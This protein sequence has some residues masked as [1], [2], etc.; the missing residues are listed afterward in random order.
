MLTI[1]IFIIVL[2]VIVFVH[3]FGHFIAAKRAGVRVDEFGFGF[4]PRIF[5]VRRGETTYSVN[6]IPLGG[7]VKLHGEGGEGRDDPRSF[8]AK[9]AWVRAI[10]LLAGV[11]MNVVLA[12]FLLTIGFTFGVRQL[13]DG[14]PPEAIVSGSEVRVLQVLP[15]APA[16]EAGLKS[17]DAIISVGGVPLTEAAGLRERVAESDGDLSLVVRRGT[18]TITLTVVP[19]ELPEA[20][21]RAIGVLPGNVGTVRYPWYLAPVKG[22]VAAFTLL[23][24]IA[25]AFWELLAGLLTG[26]GLTADLS[27]PVGIAVVTGEATRLGIMYLLQ[28]TALLSLNLAVLNA[29]PFPALDGGRFLFL[30][31][32]KL[33]GRP[34]PKNAEAVVHQA[35][36]AVLMLLVVAV[37]YRDL[38]RYGSTIGGFFRGLF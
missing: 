8:A 38:V 14:L 17:G 19:R 7:F 3:E 34:L 26:R 37:T 15:G 33:R 21:G 16:H 28:F 2:G 6:L 13:T 30:V 23:G 18:E 4:P 10:I 32:E 11:G 1:L 22:V 9:P 12:A 29:I 36:F 31:I 35:G 27:G 25:A 20:D 24:L 5:G